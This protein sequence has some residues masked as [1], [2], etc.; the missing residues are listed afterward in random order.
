MKDVP[1][2]VKSVCWKVDEKG[3]RWVVLMVQKKVELK[4]VMKVAHWVV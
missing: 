4:G 1:L 3:S 2:V